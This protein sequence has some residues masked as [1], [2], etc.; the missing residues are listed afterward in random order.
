MSRK[1]KIAVDFDGVI[2]SYTEKFNPSYIGDE[3][4]P[5]A[6]EWLSKLLRDGHTVSIFSMRNADNNYLIGLENTMNFYEMSHKTGDTITIEINADAILR[7]R[8]LIRNYLID[9]GMDPVLVWQLKFPVGKPHFD[10]YIDDRG[11]RYNGG[12]FPEITREF[13][14]PWN[15]T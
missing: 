7:G 6:I 9:H 1:L 14:K 15:R 5:G 4:V 13:C 3:P 8:N 2:S 11:Y 10:I 12:E